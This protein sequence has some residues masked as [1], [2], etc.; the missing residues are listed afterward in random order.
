MKILQVYN[1]YR[2]GGGGETVVVQNTERLLRSAGVETETYIRDS[3]EIT[4]A[5][6]KASA[7]VN[8]IYSFSAKW[9][10]DKVLAEKTPDVVHIHNLYPLFSPSILLS[11]KKVCVPV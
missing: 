1:N 5:T 6:K 4:S 8:G 7:F 2:S 9:N 10:M 11:C 3:H